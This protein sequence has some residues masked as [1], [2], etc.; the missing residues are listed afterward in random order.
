METAEKMLTRQVSAA[1]RLQAVARGL[2]A[3]RLLGRLICSCFSP[4]PH[5]SSIRLFVATQRRRPRQRNIRRRCGCR[6]RRAAS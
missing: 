4:A 2:L 5:H 3:C 1:V 6:L